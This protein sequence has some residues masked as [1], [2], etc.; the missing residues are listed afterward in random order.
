MK[1][2]IVRYR[3]I[4]G[5]VP[6]NDYFTKFV[7]ASEDKPGQITKKLRAYTRIK[8]VIIAAAE[9]NGQVRGDFSSDLKGYNFHEFLIRDGTN[10]IRILYFCYHNEKLVL[11][12][13][14]DKPSLYEKGNKK[15]VNN[16][17]EKKLAETDKYYNDFINNPKNYENFND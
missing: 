4:S 7:P 6:I 14:F 17:I 1:L 15:R 10:Q 13:G 5:F 11:L 16:F 9:N 8:T 12:N 2:E 3:T